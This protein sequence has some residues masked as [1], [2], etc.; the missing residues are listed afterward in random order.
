[1]RYQGTSDLVIPVVEDV[2]RQQL[3]GT[4]ALL[5][6]T[7]EEALLAQ[8]LLLQKNIPARLISAHEGFSLR[9]L[10]ELKCFSWY[11]HDKI[12]TELGYLPKEAWAES[13]DRISREFSD[14][15][16]LALALDVIDEFERNFGERKFWSDWLLFIQEARTEDFIFPEQNKVLVSTMHKAKGKEFDHVF[17]L[18]RNFP[19][20]EDACKRVIY[21]AITRAKKNL[22]IHTDQAF[23][24]NIVVPQIQKIADDTI[25]PVPNELQLELGMRDVALWFYK[26]AEC[27]SIIKS[28]KSGNT[29]IV[30]P[31][32][33]TGLFFSGRQVVAYS[34]KFKE[35]LEKL[36]QQGYK[37]QKAEI[38]HLVVWYSDDDGKEYRVVLPK[39]YF[40]K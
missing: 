28:L 8:N 24:D 18:L 10:L 22:F 15:A 7:N 17:I 33:S 21:V 19:I 34:T 9:Q 32:S 40:M 38:V 16:N 1:M 20:H 37:I 29:L 4:I 26:R 3:T 27:I 5:T 13:R 11:I 2:V 30:P 36:R 39:L 6:H 23:F 25:Y 35:R 31:D 14:S 12:S